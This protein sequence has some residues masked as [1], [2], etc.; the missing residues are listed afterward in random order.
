MLYTKLTGREVILEHHVM[1]SNGM[2]FVPVPAYLIG[3]EAETADFYLVTNGW[4][5]MEIYREVMDEQ[6]IF[7][8]TIVY[9]EEYINTANLRNMRIGIKYDIE[10][11]NGNIHTHHRT[12]VFNIPH[13]AERKPKRR[14]DLKGK[15]LI[16]SIK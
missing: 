2:D 16:I 1:S 12:V 10:K 8:A 4:R 6:E 15:E 9:A 11:E 3:V 14:D 13:T 5:G 7:K